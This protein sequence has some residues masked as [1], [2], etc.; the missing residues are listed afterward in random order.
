[1]A[2]EITRILWLEDM[3]HKTSV[4]EAGSYQEIGAYWDKHDATEYGEQEP[5]KFDVHIRSQRHYFPGRTAATPVRLIPATLAATF[6][7][8]LSGK[9][10][11]PFVQ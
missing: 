10:H 4:S 9:L 6:A 5:V 2:L 7:V 1:M 3:P 8:A 11:C